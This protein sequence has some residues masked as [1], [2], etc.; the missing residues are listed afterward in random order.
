MCS[1]NIQDFVADRQRLTELWAGSITSYMPSEA[2]WNIWLSLH[3]PETML[4][5]VLKTIKRWT[6]LDGAMNADYLVRYTSS[7]ANKITGDNK[8]QTQEEAQ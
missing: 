3:S 5:A 2:Q 7:L 4:K 8:P 1:S 6:K